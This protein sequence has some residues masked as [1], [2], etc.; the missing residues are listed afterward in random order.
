MYSVHYGV[1]YSTV[2]VLIEILA[3]LFPPPNLIDIGPQ[4]LNSLIQLLAGVIRQ[5]QRLVMIAITFLAFSVCVVVT[6]GIPPGT[7]SRPG[8]RIADRVLA[9]F[10]G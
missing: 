2:H 10:S 1:S 3:T 9:I 4:L 5:A 6:L 8:F 7:G